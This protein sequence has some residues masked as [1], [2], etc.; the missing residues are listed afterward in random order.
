[1]TRI[2]LGSIT[3]IANWYQSMR[4]GQY[5]RALG[6]LMLAFGIGAV[7]GAYVVWEILR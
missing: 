5:W 2:P 4:S 6:W 7:V 3:T 1:M